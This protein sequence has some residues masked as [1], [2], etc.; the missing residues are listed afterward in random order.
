MVL[1]ILTNH[2]IP[3]IKN[4]IKN[5]KKKPLDYYSAR[6]LGVIPQASQTAECLYVPQKTKTTLFLE[7]SPQEAAEKL[8][9]KLK[10]EARVL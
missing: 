3:S 6:E 5:A 8:V 10:F 2:L 7:G 9:E 4:G 1:T